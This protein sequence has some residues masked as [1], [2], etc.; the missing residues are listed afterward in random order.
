MHQL[1]TYLPGILLAY[2][3]V[4]LAM[5]SPG[6]NV[7]A[8]M[9]T[10]MEVGRKAG[11]ALALGV[12]TGSFLWAVMTVAGLSTLLAAYAA[13]LIV[14]KI[15]GGLYLLWLAFKAFRSAAS[16]HDLEVKASDGETRTTLSFY[17]RGLAIQ[18][19]NPKAAL[20]WLAIVS[21]G[22]QENAP[23]W[24]GL[25]IVIGTSVLSLIVHSCY[26]LL[27]STPPMVRLYAKARR[28]IQAALGAF[29]AVAGIRLLISR[30]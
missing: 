26:A 23:L 27:F 10:S 1:S 29:F 19:T 7:L 12:G 20:A 25:S 24:V 28:W 17:L 30:S 9:G 14:I 8:V 18:M 5:M 2:S 3:A 6:P 11:T 13:A 22:L 21:L 4:L 16:A 15:A